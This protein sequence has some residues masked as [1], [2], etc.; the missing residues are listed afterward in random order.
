MVRL[1]LSFGGGRL[2]TT[3]Y[4]TRRVLVDSIKYL[5]GLV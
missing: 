3:H 2:G 1:N 5:V 4:M